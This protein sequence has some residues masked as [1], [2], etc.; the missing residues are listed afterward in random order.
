MVWLYS[1]SMFCLLLTSYAHNKTS[2]SIGA[3]PL[4]GTAVHSMYSWFGGGLSTIGILL[5]LG[6]GFFVFAWWVPVASLFGGLFL[7]GVVYGGL[8]LG[9]TYVI[10]GFPAGAVL[11]ITS[12]VMGS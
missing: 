11:G 9:A 10:F 6:W 5:L 2:R 7:A 8:P 4:P 1:V 3:Q 12:V